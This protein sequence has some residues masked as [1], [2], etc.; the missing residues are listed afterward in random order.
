MCSEIGMQVELLQDRERVAQKVSDTLCSVRPTFFPRHFLS[1]K[2]RHISEDLQ[3][4]RE[5]QVN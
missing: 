4:M 2:C 1:L 5:I 3:E